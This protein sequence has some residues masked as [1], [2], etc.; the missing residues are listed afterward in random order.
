MRRSS[1]LHSLFAFLALSLLVP[2]CYESHVIEGAVPC[3]SSFC[4]EGNQCCRA[5]CEGGTRCQSLGLPCPDVRCMDD[6]RSDAECGGTSVCYVPNGICGGVGTCQE[7]P[8]DCTRDC[9]IVCG[10]DGNDYCNECIARRQGQSISHAG[11][12]GSE[13]C[14]FTMCRGGEHCCPLCFGDA[15][16]VPGGEPCPDVE[17]PEGCFDNAECDFGLFCQFPEGVCGGPGSCE[18]IPDGCFGDCIGV[19]GCDGAFYCNACEASLVGMSVGPADFCAS[20][21]C[22]RGGVMCATNEF[23]NLGPGCGAS[24]VSFCAPIPDT[25]PGIMDPVCGC[26]GMTYPNSCFAEQSGMTV[27]FDAPCESIPMARSCAEIHAI[28]PGLPTGT[29]PILLPSGMTQLVFCDMTTDGGGWTLVAS[30]RFQPPDDAAGPYHAD[31]AAPTPTAPHPTVW[32]GMRGSVGARSDVRFTCRPGSETRNTVDLSFYDVGWYM[33]WTTGTDAQ[34]CFSEGNGMGRD[35]PEPA[36]QD[37]VAGRSLPVGSPWLTEGF[38]EGEDSCN[39]PDDFTV[40][41]DDRGMDSNQADGTD[42]GADDREPK[43]GNQ[44]LMDGVWQLWLR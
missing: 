44:L 36:R 26:D 41:F 17:C 25:C 42:W 32:D 21:S 40:D 43:C 18:P 20:T 16:C 35:L 12:C 31:L 7:P 29:Y 10:C 1:S 2:G 23:C 30:T 27:A 33:E 19:C 6:C 39:S 37:N 9:P 38:L 3:G 15:I 8:T 22:A 5:D 28:E 24:D 11:S 13:M 4:A 14:G 34:S